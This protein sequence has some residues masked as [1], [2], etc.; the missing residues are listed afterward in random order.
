M[1]GESIHL[2]GSNDSHL[3]PLHCSWVCGECITLELALWRSL[4]SHL[5]WCVVSAYTL[6]G[7]T[8]L[9]G[10]WLSLLSTCSWVCGE[11]IHLIGSMT[12]SLLSTCS[13][14]VVSTY[15][16][17]ALWLSLL[18]TCS[19]WIRLFPSAS[20]HQALTGSAPRLSTRGTSVPPQ[21]TMTLLFCGWC[22]N[23]RL[24][25]QKLRPILRWLCWFKSS[26]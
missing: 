4:S 3:S 8:T 7:S 20:R 11:R 26:G 12:L 14:C 9:I 23:V 17:L 24:F 6:I 1:C 5:Y 22:K 16:W 19:W 25:K 18:S 10:S 21:Q 2:I 13:W 15:T